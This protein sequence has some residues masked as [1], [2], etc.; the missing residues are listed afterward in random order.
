MVPSGPSTP[1]GGSQQIPQSLLRSNSHSGISPNQQFNSLISPRTQFP[2]QPSNNTNNNI[3]M[4]TNIPNAS[5]LLNHNHNLPNGSEPDPFETHTQTQDPMQ[6]IQTYSQNP[7]QQQLRAVVKM[8]PHTGPHGA[9][10]QQI[11]PVKIERQLSENNLLFGQHQQMAQISRQNL[12]ATVLMQQQRMMQLQQQHQQQVQQQQQQGRNGNLARQAGQG[13]NGNLTRGKGDV[14][15]PGTCARR[16]TAYMHYQ[17]HKPEDNN[18]EY[19]RKFVAEFFAPNARKRWCVSLYGSGRQ[20]NG[21][22][23]Q[24]VWHCEICNRRPGRGF[25][26]TAEVLPRLYQIKFASGTLEELLY[27]DMPREYQN[28]SGQI[29]LD[30]QKAVQESVFDQLRV[31]REGQLKLVFS[32]D[33]KIC[34]WEFCARRHEELVPRRVLIPHV[35]QLGA[36][37]QKYQN[38]TQSA[39]SSLSQQDLQNTCNSFVGSA[40]QLAK[41]LEVPLVNDLGYTKRYVRCL[42]ISEV[43]NSMKDLIDYS[44]ETNTGP[45]DSL[46]NY[47]RRNG[48]PSALPAQQQQQSDDPQTI[49]CT[50]TGTSTST[51]TIT[52]T[53]NT[54]STLIPQSPYG[55]PNPNNPVPNPNPVQIPSSSSSNAVQPTQPNSSSTSNNN[56]TAVS[57]NGSAMN[58][59]HHEP[60]PAETQSSVQ[61]IL[62]DMMISSQLNGLMGDIK[63]IHHNGSNNN[64]FVGN[65]PGNGVATGVMGQTG[66]GNMRVPVANNVITMNGRGSFNGLNGVNGINGMNNHIISQDLTGMNQQQDIGNRLLNGLGPVNRYNT[67]N[68]QFDWKMSPYG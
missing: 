17:Q 29:V 42:Q 1:V 48:G 8:E 19:W 33:L 63:G 36:V 7:Q 10:P 45:M 21:V 15:E 52:N 50:G 54:N 39:T 66:Y 23:P 14:Y 31:V 57:N 51:I 68:L 43:V 11:R 38:A 28:A 5:T 27:V 46:I 35:S 58:Q 13:Q 59:V 30:Y 37:L 9:Q 4:L 60:D 6:G 32:S 18:I 49:S 56:N 41:A 53:N 62:Q 26:T 65:G 61:Q 12:N 44:R 2:N 3:T 64:S 16:L 22:F 24:D 55:N 25:E 34:S 40:R 20:T 47:P 67:N